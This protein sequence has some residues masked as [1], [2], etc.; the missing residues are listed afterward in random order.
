[1]SEPRQ[2]LKSNQST[3]PARPGKP[4]ASVPKSSPSKKAA[5]T[6]KAASPKKSAVK[7]STT[8]PPIDTEIEVYWP[9]DEKWYNCTITEILGGGKVEVTYEDGEMEVRIS[10]LTARTQ[11]RLIVFNQL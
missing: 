9:A 1:M 8:V 5:S 3:K 4:Q 11:T 6:K 2:P 10:P 7:K